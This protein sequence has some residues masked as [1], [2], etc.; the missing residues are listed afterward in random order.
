M[1]TLKSIF[2]QLLNGSKENKSPTQNKNAASEQEIKTKAETSNNNHLK[3]R[4][5]ETEN[6]ESARNSELDN[7]D[8]GENPGNREK[9]E[10]SEG[11]SGNGEAESGGLSRETD[12]GRELEIAAAYEKG[13]IDGRNQKIMELYFPDMEDGIPRFRGSASSDL[14]TGIFSLAREA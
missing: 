4:S 9:L 12:N 10:E 14:T 7:P 2:R 11:G 1:K 6:V 13:V 3:N 8:V 5:D